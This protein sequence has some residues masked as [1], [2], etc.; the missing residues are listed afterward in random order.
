MMS[1]KGAAISGMIIT[2][3]FFLNL[4]PFCVL[5]DSGDTHSF[6]YTRTAL[7]IDLKHVKA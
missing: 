3:T 5:F 6:I 7:L 4:R 1:K 2:S